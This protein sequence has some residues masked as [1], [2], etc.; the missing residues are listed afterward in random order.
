MRLL[1]IRHGQTVDNVHGRLGT[2]VPGPPL[3]E[4]GR[5]QAAA[6]PD[7]LAADEIEAIYAS[8]MLRTR[9]TAEPLAHARGLPIRVIDGIQEIAAGELE[10]RSDQDAI[11]AYMGTIFSW[12]HDFDA[13]IPGGEDG[14]GFYER[15]TAAIN[16]IAASHAGT[17]A[18]VSHGAAIRTWV[19]WTS[20]NLDEEFSRTHELPNT[21]M[22]TLEG[23]TADGWVTT[24][25]AGE[26]LGGLALGDT[27]AQDPTGEAH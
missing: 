8:T 13:R 10:G 20:T 1:L 18:I 25:W 3:T 16:S 22:I 2:V 7:A 5:E 19:S 6:I 23:S 15:F 11:R 26:P 9:L 27:T 24:H 21:A 12:W 4:L 14:N 17:V